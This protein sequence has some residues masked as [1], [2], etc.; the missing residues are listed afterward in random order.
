MDGWISLPQQ[1]VFFSNNLATE[2][3][4]FLMELGIAIKKTSL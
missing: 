3:A 1:D 4:V 2:E